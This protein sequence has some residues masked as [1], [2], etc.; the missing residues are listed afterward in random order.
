MENQNKDDNKI[1]SLLIDSFK[2]LALTHENVTKQF[3]AKH[4]YFFSAN[5]I[6]VLYVLFYTLRL[7]LFAKIILC[8]LM[9]LAY[10]AIFAYCYYYV[11]K[12]SAN[13]KMYSAALKQQLHLLKE[14][15]SPKTNDIKNHTEMY[16]E[17]LSHNEYMTT[18]M[19]KYNW[20]FIAVPSIIFIG[21]MAIL[22]F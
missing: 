14:Y 20:L 17:K 19:I 10:L 8:S 11:V 4:I 15:P 13:I 1:D 3:L 5:L 6:V 2:I 18:A 9:Y 16:L 22:F 7:S 12:L 21:S